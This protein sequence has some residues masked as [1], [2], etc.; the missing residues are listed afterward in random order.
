MIKPL[1]L[2]IKFFTGRKKCPTRKVFL[3]INKFKRRILNFENSQNFQ[4]KFQY[5][6][7]LKKEEEKKNHYKRIRHVTPNMPIRLTPIPNY[8]FNLRHR[9][10]HHNR[11]HTDKWKSSHCGKGEK[12]RTRF[13]FFK[14]IKGIN[15][16]MSFQF[17]K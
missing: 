16:S 4:T 6:F 1:R 14:L 11:A 7:N 3:L 17:Q 12:I 8:L 5:N 13:H 9:I 2:K 10:P 15:L